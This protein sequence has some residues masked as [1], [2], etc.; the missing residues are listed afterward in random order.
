MENKEV[1][2]GKGREGWEGRRNREKKEDKNTEVEKEQWRQGSAK[3]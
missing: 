1:N 2:R 3:L